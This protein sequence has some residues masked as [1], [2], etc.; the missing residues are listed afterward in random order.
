MKCAIIWSQHSDTILHSLLKIQWYECEIFLDTRYGS[1]GQLSWEDSIE[2][3]SLFLDRHDWS[4]FD[5][6]VLPP[7]YELWLT[8]WIDTDRRWISFK[9]LPLYYRYIYNHVLPYSKV[10]KIGCIGYTHHIERFSLYR[11]DLISSYQLLS[12]QASNK[13]F[14][15]HFPLYTLST[16]HRSI[17]YDLPRQ[18]FTNKLIK[19]DLKKLKDYAID[20]LIP[21][22]WW[23]FKYHKVF[24]QTFHSTVKFH[25]IRS[26]DVLI[27]S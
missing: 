3:V 27:L 2:R 24:L 25:K 16:D 26:D 12:R 10:G 1:W 21:L 22:E 11:G 20:T 17:L 4:S 19:H 8:R 5:T 18:R 9:V 15:R 13:Y 7:L 23:Y 14:Q 6:L